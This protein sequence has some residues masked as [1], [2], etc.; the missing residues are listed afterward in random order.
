MKTFK[1]YKDTKE[2]SK[3]KS[4]SGY[5]DI[6]DETELSE[7]AIKYI[8]ASIKKGDAKNV[9]RQSKIILFPDQTFRLKGSVVENCDIFSTPVI[10]TNCTLRNNI[11]RNCHM[12]MSTSTVLDECHFRGGAV[13]IEQSNPI[14]FN[15]PDGS[16]FNPKKNLISFFG[17]VNS[18]DYFLKHL[19]KYPYSD[20]EAD[21][22]CIITMGSR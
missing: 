17:Y 13:D 2:Y 18:Y 14:I 19:D 8:I 6:D 7:D 10:I 4:F 21:I 12:F 16:I 9:I 11:I 1:E 5:Y 3:I 20:Y 22:N 15:H